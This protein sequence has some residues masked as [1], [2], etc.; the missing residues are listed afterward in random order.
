MKTVDCKNQPN[1]VLCVYIHLLNKRYSQRQYLFKRGY[2]YIFIY[3]IEN[4]SQL[5]KISKEVEGFNAQLFFFFKQ[6]F[7]S[8]SNRRWNQ[9]LWYYWLYS[10]VYWPYLLKVRTKCD[11][12]ICNTILISYF[13]ID[14]HYLVFLIWFFVNT[15]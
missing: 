13:Y 7:R 5:I 9:Y 8:W 11:L 12:W 1:K 15:N 3:I 10:S 4:V 14:I 6:V 2:I